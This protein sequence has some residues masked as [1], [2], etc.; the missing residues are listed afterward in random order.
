MFNVRKNVNNKSKRPILRNDPSSLPER[1]KKTMKIS[2][3]TDNSRAE[4][5][6][7]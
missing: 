1:L 4:M 6:T 3:S 2:V 7:W 5:Q